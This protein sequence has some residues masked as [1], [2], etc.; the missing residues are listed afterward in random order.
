[1]K[2]VRSWRTPA[3]LIAAGGIALS[4]MGGLVTWQRQHEEDQESRLA[5]LEQREALTG[6][7]LGDGQQTILA[8]LDVLRETLGAL[9]EGLHRENDAILR[10]LE[11]LERKR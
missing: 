4:L 9:R 3:T 11:T 6:Q 10:R 2:A 7:A 8:R 1:M 5:R